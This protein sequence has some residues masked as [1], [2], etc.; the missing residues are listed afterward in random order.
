M[1]I[2]DIRNELEAIKEALLSHVR[3]QITGSQLNAKIQDSAPTIKIREIVGIPTGPGA[4]RKFVEEYL[5][6][7]LEPSGHQGG[8]V[9]Y[10]I[11]GHPTSQ[12]R[13]DL[14]AGLWRTFVSPATPFKL[15]ISKLNGSLSIRGRSANTEAEEIE[16][17]GVTLEEHDK[18][19]MEF[20]ESLSPQEAD[21]LDR[22]GASKAEFIE[23]TRLLKQ[24]ATDIYKKWGLYRKQK[25]LE[26][27]L[28]RLIEL[29]IEQE[30]QTRLLQQ[31]DESQGLMRTRENSSSNE[32]SLR[33]YAKPVPE[34]NRGKVESQVAYA[35]ELARRAI[36][37]MSYDELR[38]LRIP[39]GVL[40][41]EV[42]QKT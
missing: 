14:G 8:D 10:G 25:L 22:I 28:S 40:V 12:N 20:Q 6:D 17:R 36:E 32:R 2:S 9:V 21:R 42:Y 7:L 1:E 26:V 39:L 19:R 24:Q 15:L 31:I 4:L 41:D 16:V 35:R 5:C 18:I 38:S 34:Q 13:L 33:D 27:F 23:W 29:D 30:L 11:K 37:L 3:N